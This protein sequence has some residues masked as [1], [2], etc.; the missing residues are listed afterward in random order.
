MKARQERRRSSPS[1]GTPRRRLGR[2]AGARFVQHSINSSHTKNQWFTFKRQLLQTQLAWQLQGV[3][4]CA[5]PADFWLPAGA[6]GVASHSS[7]LM[8]VLRRRQW[9]RAVAGS[10]RHAISEPGPCRGGRSKA[11]DLPMPAVQY[12][13]TVWSGWVVCSTTWVLAHSLLV[14]TRPA[15]CARRASARWMIGAWHACCH[16]FLESCCVGTL[17]MTMPPLLPLRVRTDMSH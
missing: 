17:H 4:G 14:A 10:A 2:G 6:S 3:S 12:R 13:H 16:V 11:R 9:K 7:L 5:T 8:Q 1:I 15:C